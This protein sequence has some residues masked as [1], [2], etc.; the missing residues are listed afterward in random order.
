MFASCVLIVTYVSGHLMK[1]AVLV[2][3]ASSGGDFGAGLA[4]ALFAAGGRLDQGH[5]S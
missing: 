2:A 1:I 5:F 4:G 3:V